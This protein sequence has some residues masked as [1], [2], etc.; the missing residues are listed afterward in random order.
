[1]IHDAAK[2]LDVP[3]GPDDLAML[4]RAHHSIC[5]FRRFQPNSAQAEESAK[6]LINLFQSGIR[7]RH[8]LIAM[9]TGRKFP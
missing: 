5:A 1:M 4:E 9:M 2:K 8:Q 3:L 6:L 7:N